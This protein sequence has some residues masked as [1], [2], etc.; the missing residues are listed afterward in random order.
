MILWHFKDPCSTVL[1]MSCQQSPLFSNWTKGIMQWNIHEQ[2][3][4]AS[5]LTWHARASVSSCV[6]D[7]GHVCQCVCVPEYACTL[8]WAVTSP[9][10]SVL[11]PG[12]LIVDVCDLTAY[13]SAHNSGTTDNVPSVYRTDFAWFV[14]TEMC[15]IVCTVLVANCI[16]RW[17]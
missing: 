13:T 4:S 10:K 11:C 12:R 9:Y 17:V 6:F 3:T 7:V 16:T 5:S 14:W 8:V 15:C 1:I 2:K